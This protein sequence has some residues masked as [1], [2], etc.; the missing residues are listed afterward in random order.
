MT[1]AVLDLFIAAG[2]VQALGGAAGI[3]QGISMVTCFA[4]LAGAT[5]SAM[6]ERATSG[7]K[8]SLIIAAIAALAWLITTAFFTAGG[9]AGNITPQAIN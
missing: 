6:S 4:S 3:I 1:R 8:V 9:W 5:I 2:L 7:I